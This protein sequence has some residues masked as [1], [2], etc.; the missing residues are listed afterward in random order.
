MSE[1]TFTPHKQNPKHARE[2]RDITRPE[3]GYYK[4]RMKK[5]A[6]EVG[7]RIILAPRHHAWDDGPSDWFWWHG[8]INNRPDPDAGPMISPN[9]LKVWIDGTRITIIEYDYLIQVRA[10]DKTYRPLSPGANPERRID[11]N[12]LS[13]ADLFQ[14]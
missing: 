11:L 5:D 3:T 10:W 2:L 8:E 9:V 12:K 6:P 14:R 7:A 1:R 13:P 4:L